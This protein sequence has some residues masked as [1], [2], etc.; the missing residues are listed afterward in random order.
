MTTHTLSP[1]SLLDD[2]YNHNRYKWSNRQWRLDVRIYYFEQ[3]WA[4]FAGF[5]LPWA[6]LTYLFPSFLD[7]GL[8]AFLFPLFVVLALVAHPITGL[9]VEPFDGEPIHLQQ[10]R[11]YEQNLLQ[12]CLPLFSIARLLNSSFLR[13]C[14]RIIR[15]RQF[16]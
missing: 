15:P 11:L 3:R 9:S 10:K 7:Q 5:G 16:Q 13:C 4:Y 8:I 2:N 12:P 14:H 6:S 1:L